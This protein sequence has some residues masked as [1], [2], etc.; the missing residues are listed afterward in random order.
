M[1][2]LTSSLPRLSSSL[3]TCRSI[4]VLPIQKNYGNFIHGE[5]TTPEK[6]YSNFCPANGEVLCEVPE[7]TAFEVEQAVASAKEAF[8]VWSAMSSAERGR[9]LTKAAHIMREHNAEVSFLFF[10]S[11]FLSLLFTGYV[12]SF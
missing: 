8:P 11:F 5:Y 12:R 3:L 2:R 7:T 4:S 6:L 9:I 10:L 1:F